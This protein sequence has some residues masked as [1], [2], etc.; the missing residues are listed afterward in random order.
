MA[1][2][3]SLAGLKKGVRTEDLISGAPPDLKVVAL[4]E[5]SI[6]EVTADV[7]EAY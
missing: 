2:A 6:K 4:L 1:R 3:G 7:Y 5:A